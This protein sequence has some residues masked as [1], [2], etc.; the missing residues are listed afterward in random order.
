MNHARRRRAFVA[1]FRERRGV[2]FG[3][4]KF[5]WPDPPVDTEPRYSSARYTAPRRY[6]S[7]ANIA[8]AVVRPA[9]IQAFRRS[10]E[11]NSVAARSSPRK[12]DVLLRN[13]VVDVARAR[14]KRGAE[15]TERECIYFLSSSTF[16][17][18]LIPRGRSSFTGQRRPDAL[19]SYNCLVSTRKKNCA[20]GTR[21]VS[22]GERHA[23]IEVCKR[24]KKKKK[25]E[26]RRERES[27]RERAA[28]QQLYFRRQDTET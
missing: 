2:K 12:C 22:E 7:L 10:G 8:A 26:G 3:E 14:A 23:R 18:P 27:E 19:V 1:R 15:T 9:C 24:R 4:E 28:A 16:P 20:V 11:R 13:D 17:A 21:G 6:I 25:K 5:A